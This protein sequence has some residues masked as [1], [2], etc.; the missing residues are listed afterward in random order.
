MTEG[1][2]GTFFSVASASATAGSFGINVLVSDNGFPTAAVV[3]C[4]WDIGAANVS[5]WAVGNNM[6]AVFPNGT[7]TRIDRLSG[8]RQLG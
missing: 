5:T 1:V 8:V 7:P 4:E 3:G 2:A 6:I